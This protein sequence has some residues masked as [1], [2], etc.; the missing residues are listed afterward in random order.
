M[1][2]R[3]CIAAIMA[4]KTVVDRPTLIC[5]KTV[6]G[7]GSPNKAGTHEAHGAALGDK[8]VA[9]TRHAL[10]WNYPPFVVPPRRR[11]RPGTRA[12]SGAAAEA[13]WR[14]RFAEYARA[15]PAEAR[16]FERRMR[17]E[18]PAGFGAQVSAL[19]APGRRK[20]PRQSRRARRRRTPSRHWRR[21]F[22]SSSAAPPISPARISPCG[23]AARRD[24]AP[25][26]AITFTT[27]YANSA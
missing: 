14:G 12:T 16:E 20:E 6:I 19:M 7:K 23:R 15:H 5:C 10:G 27:A 24:S 13:T 3:P 8:E 25:R 2:A 1:T 17:G 26:A 18:L 11:A 22:P 21:C 9:A 4:A